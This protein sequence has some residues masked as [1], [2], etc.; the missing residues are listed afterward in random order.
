MVAGCK[1]KQL[2][3]HHHV[4]YFRC[5]G[6]CALFWRD[7]DS[8]HTGDTLPAALFALCV[9]NSYLAREKAHIIF[10]CLEATEVSFSCGPSEA[11]TAW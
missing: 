4:R 1:G 8:L 5:S 6:L 7:Q 2:E 10:G 9:P 3:A 11:W